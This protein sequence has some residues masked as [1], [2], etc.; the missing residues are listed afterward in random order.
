MGGKKPNPNRTKEMKIYP[1]VQVHAQLE[2]LATMG[3]K[4]TSAS[5]VAVALIGD[6]IEQLMKDKILKVPET[7]GG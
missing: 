5:S 1:S 7:D 3:F 2:Q 4:G 6:R